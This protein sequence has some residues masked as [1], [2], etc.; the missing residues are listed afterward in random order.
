MKRYTK[1]VVTLLLCICFLFALA[2]SLLASSGS[3][4]LDENG[5]WVYQTDGEQPQEGNTSDPDP[6][7]SDSGSEST[8]GGNKNDSLPKTG[9]SDWS[10]Y[11]GMVILY[12]VLCLF[13]IG[14][15]AVSVTRRRRSQS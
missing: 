9:S 3:W 4:V 6:A 12:S 7:P 8:T 1:H 10:D 13:L 14:F 2:P 15:G 11:A 5:T